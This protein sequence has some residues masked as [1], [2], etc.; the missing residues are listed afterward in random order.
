M[1][2]VIRPK[3]HTFS[4]SLNLYAHFEPHNMGNL[5][6][7][8]KDGFSNAFNNSPRLVTSPTI[9]D[10]MINEYFYELFEDRDKEMGEKSLDVVE[11]DGQN[12]MFN[13]PTDGDM[14]DLLD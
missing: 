5:I 12:S 13:F 8:S 2:T 11:Q 3:P 14:W 9:S 6:T 7:S 1:V 4:K 10:E